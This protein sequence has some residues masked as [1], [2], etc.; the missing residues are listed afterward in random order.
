MSRLKALDVIGPDGPDDE[1]APVGEAVEI[2]GMKAR[3]APA[4]RVWERALS[5]EADRPRDSTRNARLYE[6]SEIGT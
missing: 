1:Q 2:H 3:P 6:R 4:R 5:P